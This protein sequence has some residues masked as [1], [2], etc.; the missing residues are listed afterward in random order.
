VREKEALVGMVEVESCQTTSRISERREG[1][2]NQKRRRL[3]A[4]DDW[5]STYDLYGLLYPDLCVVLIVLDP[6]P[7]LSLMSLARPRLDISLLVPTIILVPPS[8]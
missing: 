7:A 8:P 4:M 2:E 5:L 1:R 6:H 3:K